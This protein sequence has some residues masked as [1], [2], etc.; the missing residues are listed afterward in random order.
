MAVVILRNKNLHTG[1]H[2]YLFS[3]SV[4]DI[5]L[6]IFGLPQEI[7]YLWQKYPYM[8]IESFCIFQIIVA[9]TCSNASILTI[10]VLSVEH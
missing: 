5:L 4:S 3:L 1:V 7:I 8:F 10:M 9:E 2:F 6:L